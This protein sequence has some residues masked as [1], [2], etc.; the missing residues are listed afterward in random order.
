MAE[1]YTIYSEN[2]DPYATPVISSLIVDGQYHNVSGNPLWY[3]NSFSKLSSFNNVQTKMIKNDI[4]I[5]PPGVLAI[6]DNF[7]VYEKPPT[8]QNI[9]LYPSTLDSMPSE[10]SDKRQKIFRLPIPW[11]LYIADFYTNPEDN[12]CYTTSVS[13]F[14]MDSQL[15][16]P[17]Q[18]LYLPPLSNFYCNASLCRPFFSSMEDIERYPKNIAGIIE[19]SYDWIWSGGSNLDLTQACAQFYIQTLNQQQSVDNNSNYL[20]SG[21]K[22]SILHN[23]LGHRIPRLSY[24]T[25]YVDYSYYETYLSAWENIPIENITSCYWPNPSLQQTYNMEYSSLY[26]AHVSE[27]IE[28]LRENDDYYNEDCDDPDCS[29]HE[30]QYTEDSINHDDFMEYVGGSPNAKVK[31]YFDII[32]YKIA[33]DNLTYS[34][35]T[36]DQV[37]SIFDN[38]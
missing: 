13:M 16:S 17:D 33:L 34:P 28:Y 15:Y 2:P 5:L 25:Y 35:P 14:F 18:N 11:Q 22:T 26:D 20:I 23:A 36:I 6:A 12:T 38:I 10:I 30:N 31:S 37:F 3:S 9:F 21:N 29:C 32:S 1:Y 8:Y 19:S 7:V 4:G 27:Y 24:G